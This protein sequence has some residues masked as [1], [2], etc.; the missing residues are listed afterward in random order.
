MKQYKLI[1]IILIIFLKTGNVLSNENIFNVNNIEIAKEPNISNKQLA[2]K[3][4]KLAFS[5][6]KKK[7]L[8]KNDQLRLSNLKYKEIEQLVLYYQIISP[9]EEEQN[10]NKI[11]FNIFFDKEK[12]HNLFYQK[13]I[14]YSEI[15]D[16]ELY[17]L[18]IFKKGEKVFIYNKNFFYE[19]WNSVYQNDLIEIILPLENIE[20]IQNI[21]S[22]KDNLL[23]LNLKYL[24][25]EYSNKNLALVIIEDT[26]SNKE[27][28]YIKTKI[29]NKNIDKNIIIEKLNL[30]EEKFYEKIINEISE[31]IIFI[32]KSQNLIDVRTPSF[33]NTKLILNNRN[34]LAELNNRLKKI[35]LIDNIFIQEYNNKFVLIK[36][37]YHGKLNKIIKQLE[38]QKIVLESTEDR[39]SLKIQ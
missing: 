14:L 16:K 21:N 2:N 28:V 38:K 33:L 30:N 25:E 36:I 13:N 4:I 27:K 9:K 11:K 35:G 3:A 7:I 22:N 37:K 34:N 12:L 24:F 6:L 1:V 8:L 26:G 10:L 17:L 29:L 20:L 15:Y 32:V 31:E 5:D 39:W 23:E 18:P 19:N